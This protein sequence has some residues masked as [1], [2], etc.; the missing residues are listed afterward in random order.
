[1]PLMQKELMVRCQAL[2]SIFFSAAAVEDA[3]QPAASIEV[4]V[5]LT[6]ALRQ[7]LPET[8]SDLPG[9]PRHAVAGQDLM[10][11]EVITVERSTVA[12]PM[13]AQCLPPQLPDV[14]LHKLA[15]EPCM[16]AEDSRSDLKSVGALRSL[17]QALA[18]TLPPSSAT[19]PPR[20]P[21]FPTQH[22]ADAEHTTEELRDAA[23]SGSL[24]P[25]PLEEQPPSSSS[26][27]PTP[28]ALPQSSQPTATDASATEDLRAAALGSI[29]FPPSV[30][31]PPSS[32][33][34]PPTPRSPPPPL[35]HRAPTP[36]PLPSESQE[37]PQ[38]IDDV[39]EPQAALPCPP[40]PPTPPSS[41]DGFSYDFDARMPLLSRE[42]W[43]DNEQPTEDL[44]ATASDRSQSLPVQPGAAEGPEAVQTQGC[45]QMEITKNEII[46]SPQDDLQDV[47]AIP[48][49]D[50]QEVSVSP[51]ASSPASPGQPSE[52][53]PA[54]RGVH[55]ITG[56][57]CPARQQKRPAHVPPLDLSRVIRSIDKGSSALGTL[58]MDEEA[59]ESE[60][61]EGLTFDFV[62]S[63]T[64]FWTS[65]WELELDRGTRWW[66]FE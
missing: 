57:G 5:A 18:R 53:S 14:S 4:P 3:F 19:Q 50:L 1:M 15:Q 22:E 34:R 12:P 51:Q 7:P 58:R 23:A 26:R 31:K 47:S 56:P 16:H 8:D 48:H 55:R 36:P 35:P 42:P 2:D 13:E 24:A 59:A 30:G 43:A 32:V 38:D 20:L 49:D 45:L 28:H 25:P 63:L 33:S 6:K 21:P 40:R 29:A 11:D 66:E 62:G 37:R 64:S 44:R 9:T 39:T 17:G 52:G 46:A 54:R 61:E 41:F 27:P 60:L 65:W 10:T